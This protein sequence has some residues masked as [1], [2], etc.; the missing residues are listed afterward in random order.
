MG[1]LRLLYES[2]GKINPGTNYIYLYVSIVELN[3]QVRKYI[4]NC[5]FL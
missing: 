3:S 1:N 2:T 4:S 5:I